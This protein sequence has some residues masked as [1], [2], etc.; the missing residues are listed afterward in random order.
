MSSPEFSDKGKENEDEKRV[1]AKMSQLAACHGD[2]GR[3][4]E[5]LDKKRQAWWE[6]KGGSMALNGTLP[7]QAYTMLLLIYMGLDPVDVPVV[8]E[9]ERKITWR[10]FNFCPMLEAC[11]RLGL[12]TRLVCRQGT[13]AS[14]QNL[15]ARL[16]PR[17]R[18]SRNYRDGMRPYA[19][20]CEES[21]E[22]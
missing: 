15:V 20:Y 5:E 13:E 16:D 22:I 11:R 19:A 6:A 4:H 17:L 14:V 21:I 3:L 18:F 7:R 8:C 10:S 1:A 12:D 2:Y 9:D